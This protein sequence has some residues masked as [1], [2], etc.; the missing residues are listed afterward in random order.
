MNAPA[1][2]AQDVCAAARTWLRVPWRH[3]GRNAAGVD[4]LGLLVRV[5]LDLGLAVQD[6]AGYG[7]Q[8]GGGALLAELRRQCTERAGPPQPG[9]VALM[10]F[11]R[12]PQHVAFVVPYALGG[13]AIV[14]ALCTA[15]CVTE[16]RLDD[17]WR[18][19][20]VTLFDLPGVER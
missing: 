20:I 14:H 19:H 15:G 5:A 1:V 10:R 3:Q 7:R 18:R 4:C 11:K 16:H 2:S 6:R 9:M 17:A 13:L 12:E 8:P